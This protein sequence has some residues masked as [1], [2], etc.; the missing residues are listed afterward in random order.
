MGCC[1]EGDRGGNAGVMG[2]PRPDFWVEELVGSFSS[3]HVLLLLFIV[4]SSAFSC[5]PTSGAGL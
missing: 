1:L 3:Y 2:K 4:V 5:C